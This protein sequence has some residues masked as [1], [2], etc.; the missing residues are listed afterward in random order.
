MAPGFVSEEITPVPGA[1]EIGGMA[2]G[3]PGFPRRF[4]WGDRE[5]GVEEILDRWKTT[6]EDRGDVYVRRHWF[7]IRTAD[8]ET[9][10]IYFRRQA[11]R[12]GRPARGRWWLYAVD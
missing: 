8:G 6:G 4:R 11:P 5:I 10:R 3:E 12:P 9:M 7:R 2:V 1:L